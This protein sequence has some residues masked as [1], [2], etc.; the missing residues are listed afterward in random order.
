M[1]NM[2]KTIIVFSGFV[3]FLIVM[4]AITGSG[5]NVVVGGGYTIMEN[6]MVIGNLSGQFQ[7]MGPK[8][9][10]PVPPCYTSTAGL[11][12]EHNNW[13]TIPYP[14]PGKSIFYYHDTNNLTPRWIESDS[15]HYQIETCWWTN[16]WGTT[17]T[18]G[19][20]INLPACTYTMCGHCVWCCNHAVGGEYPPTAGC[21]GWYWVTTNG[22][23]HA[24]MHLLDNH[25]INCH[26][27]NP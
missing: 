7:P 17:N 9:P 3:L 26:G 8:P 24:D 11:C 21:F 2:K 13:T 25:E 15:W 5:Q 4:F 1:T 27:T 22:I 12:S 23:D 10:P 19:I 18:N 20:V 14:C 16:S 6:G